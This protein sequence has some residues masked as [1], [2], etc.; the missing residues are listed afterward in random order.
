M[1]NSEPKHDQSGVLLRGLNDKETREFLAHPWICRLAT[2]Q[3]DGAPH[4]VP[5]WFEYNPNEHC[6]YLVARER[7][8]YVE[9]IKDEPRGAVSIADDSAGNRRVLIQ[10]KAEIVDGPSVNGQWVPIGR[11]MA[12]RYLGEDKGPRYLIP[13]L[14]RPRYLI[15]IPLEKVRSW[16]GGEWHPRYR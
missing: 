2:V 3:P 5:L 14:N 9:H 12:S 8:A 11:R 4:V 16:Q 13:T 7:S 1:A 6:L 10:G 15:R